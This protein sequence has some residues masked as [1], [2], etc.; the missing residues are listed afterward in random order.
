MKKPLGLLLAVAII[1]LLSIKTAAAQTVYYLN[2]TS[3]TSVQPTYD[4]V[5]FYQAL[6]PANFH[7]LE[8]ESFSIGGGLTLNLNNVDNYQL[9]PTTN[10]LVAGGF[11]TSSTSTFSLT[12]LTPGST[13]SLYAIGAWD[14]GGRA[15]YVSFGGSDPVDSTAS[16]AGW[17]TTSPGLNV[18]LGDLQLIT[19]DVL[20]DGTG[21]INGYISNT[22]G[23][24]P[25]AEGQVGGF[26][27]VVN[28]PTSV[29][30]P[31]T[32]ILLG[33]GGIGLFF[34]ARRRQQVV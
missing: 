20:V 26:A 10:P 33:F 1:S 34:V 30:E 9:P 7:T 15:A 5:N 28:A 13:V 6:H 4:G 27:F 31:S 3:D 29:P 2:F 8:N 17:N 24:A 18:T 23:F 16:D 32:Y 19:S 21:T 12:G 25:K 14:G 11:F 22:D